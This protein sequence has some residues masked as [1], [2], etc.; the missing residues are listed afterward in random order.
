MRYGIED[1][2][3]WELN[4]VP[5]TLS[6]ENEKLEYEDRGVIFKED[7]SQEYYNLTM[8]IPAIL[9]YNNTN[10]TCVAIAPDFRRIFSR[11]VHMFVFDT[12]R[13]IIPPSLTVIIM[14]I[15]FNP[16]RTLSAINSDC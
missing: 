13:T 8:I 2:A 16:C 15:V 10:I 4:K 5:I 12:L 1:D 9:D 7:I 14:I 6:F 3:H 11:N